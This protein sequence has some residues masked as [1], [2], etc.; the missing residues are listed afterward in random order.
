MDQGGLTEILLGKQ[1]L[2][3]T[4]LGRAIALFFSSLTLLCKYLRN[5]LERA[6]DPRDRVA[7]LDILLSA[8][9]AV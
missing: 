6:L 5:V 9:L 7:D 4:D 1:R 2:E 3:R 8:D